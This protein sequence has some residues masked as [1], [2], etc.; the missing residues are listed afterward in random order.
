MHLKRSQ[1]SRRTR[2]NHSALSCEPRRLKFESLEDRRLLALRSRGGLFSRTLPPMT[3]ASQMTWEYANY[4]LALF[5]LL[6]VYLFR[7]LFRRSA[8][9]RYNAIL[10]AQGA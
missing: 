6:A 5:G 2:R 10:E 1:S 8:K 7:G 4:G 9:R 3:Q